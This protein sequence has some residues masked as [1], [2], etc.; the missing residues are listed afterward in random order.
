MTEPT[1]NTEEID[2]TNSSEVVARYTPFVKS[3]TAKIRRGLPEH[4]E[5]DDLIDYGMI[6][7]LEAAS[8]FDPEA[9]AHVMTFAYY[10]VRGAIYDG[11]RQMG[12]LSRSHYKRAR[13]EAQANDYL[14]GFI[15]EAPSQNNE[16]LESS[17][18]SLADAVE[19]LAMVFI[20]S[21]DAENAEELVDE[22]V[23][24]DE[25]INLAQTKKILRDAVERLPEQERMMMELYYFK[26]LGL[27]EVGQQLGVSKSWACRLHARVIDKLK[28]MVIDS[29]GPD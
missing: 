24:V 7:L 21:L 29:L 25:R 20:T 6:G 14:E 12:W 26:G 22:S 19:G 3:I 1:P 15:Q 18:E 8:R 10:R 4:I 13:F 5:F 11:L 27:H 9:G 16:N 28:R 23:A 17:V 2:Y